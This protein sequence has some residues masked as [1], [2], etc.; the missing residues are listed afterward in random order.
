MELINK[1]KCP[2]CGRP[3]EIWTKKNDNTYAGGICRN[4]LINVD[5]TISRMT[6]EQ[7]IECA[8]D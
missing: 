8:Q 3:V 5:T 4:C 6:Q 2:S 7:I 1:P